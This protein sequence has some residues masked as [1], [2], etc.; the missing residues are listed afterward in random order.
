MDQP[1][2]KAGS[3]VPTQGQENRRNLWILT[4]YA[5][6]FVA[7]LTFLAYFFSTYVAK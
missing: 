7:L 3:S 6:A 5:A 4:G 1:V 2:T